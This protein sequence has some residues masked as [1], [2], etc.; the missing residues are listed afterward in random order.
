MLIFRTLSTFVYVLSIVQYLAKFLV[1][2]QKSLFTE[3]SASRGKKFSI[4]FATRRE[5][6][7]LLFLDYYSRHAEEFLLLG[8][9]FFA[10]RSWLILFRVL[11]QIRL[12]KTQRM[13]QLKR[14]AKNVSRNHLNLSF[15]IIN[16]LNGDK[17]NNCTICD[18]ARLLIDKI[19][20][21]QY[22]L[23]YFEVSKR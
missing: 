15:L 19:R 7:R 9:P 10:R 23:N 2:F 3:H 8:Y 11:I 12:K 4:S 5:Q 13:S 21:A 18:H 22:I 14:Y 17:K 6:A 16:F 1:Y 20:N